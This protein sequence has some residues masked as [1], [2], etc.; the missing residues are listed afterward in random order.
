MNEDLKKKLDEMENTLKSIEKI[1]NPSR[2]QLLVQGLWRGI[3]YIIGV[4]VALAI[5]GWILNVMGIIPIFQNF[6]NE[7]RS[8][9]E[10]VKI[11]RNI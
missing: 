1:L 5:I 7:M 11:N 4:L 8:N 2:W 9:L 10:T 3:G 6:S